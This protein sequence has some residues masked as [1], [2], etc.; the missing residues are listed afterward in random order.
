MQINKFLKKIIGIEEKDEFIEELKRK[1]EL[2]QNF[3]N[4]MLKTMDD[5]VYARWLSG[6]PELKNGEWEEESKKLDKI[7]QDS[8]N[9]GLNFLALF[10][11]FLQ[12]AK[13]DLYDRG[14]KESCWV[15][16]VL[17]RK[18]IDFFPDHNSVLNIIK[19]TNILDYED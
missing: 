16:T 17:H 6:I 15:L 11:I 14:S 5:K 19:E 7:I 2:Y 10:T 8:Q 9:N 12:Y 13:A 4:R 1:Q 3:F 18:K